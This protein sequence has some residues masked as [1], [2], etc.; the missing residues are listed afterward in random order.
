[1]SWSVCP[2]LGGKQSWEHFAHQPCGRSMRPYISSSGCRFTPPSQDAGIILLS[3]GDGILTDLPFRSP[4]PTSVSSSSTNSKTRLFPLSALTPWLF[5]HI[6]LSSWN[7]IF[8]FVVLAR[9]Y[10][11]IINQAYL[12]F[13]CSFYFSFSIL[14]PLSFYIES[15]IWQGSRNHKWALCFLPFVF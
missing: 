1:M 15:N 7:H 2:L 3:M 5:S 11:I 13:L 9:S 8:F 6:I 10:D 4:D 12:N 14:F